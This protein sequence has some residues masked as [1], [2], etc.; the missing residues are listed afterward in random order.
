MAEWLLVSLPCQHCNFIIF[1]RSYNMSWICKVNSTHK[2]KNLEFNEMAAKGWLVSFKKWQKEPSVSMQSWGERENNKDIII[3]WQTPNILISE[4]WIC[5]LQAGQRDELLGLAR[6]AWYL[7]TLTFQY[8]DKN[9]S[10][11]T[12]ETLDTISSKFKLGS[13]LSGSISSSWLLLG[14][15]FNLPMKDFS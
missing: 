5:Y 13:E 7:M 2:M 8:H 12:E 3:A 6:K 1:L 11:K 9:P 4:Q 10:P 15:Q 14:M